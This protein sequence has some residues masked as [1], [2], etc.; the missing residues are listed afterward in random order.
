MKLKIGMSNYLAWIIRNV[1]LYTSFLYPGTYSQLTE[2]GVLGG[3]I[4]INAAH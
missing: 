4:E 2:S 3:L 1:I